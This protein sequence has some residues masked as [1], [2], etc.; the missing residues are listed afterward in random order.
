VHESPKSMLL[1][2]VVLAI[3]SIIAGFVGVP[4]V[5]GGANHIEHFLTAASHETESESLGASAIEGLLMVV[6]TGAALTGL[7]LA[8]L[9]YVARPEL[10]QKLANKA[11]AMYSIMVN[12]Y[13]VDEVYDAVIV[14]PVVR[15]SREFLWKFMDVVMIDGAVNGTGNL[16]RGS[17]KALRHMQT[18]YVRTYAVWI[19][20]GGVLVV[21]WFLR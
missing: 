16:I 4:P 6:S 1:P 8:Y 2:V 12:K 13:Y 20:L 11:H 21:V 17:A 3:F 7:F 14:W 18:G 10:P 9:F 5:L 19:L 15:M